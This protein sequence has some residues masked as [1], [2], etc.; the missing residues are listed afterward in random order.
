[1]TALFA[2]GF[3]NAFDLDLLLLLHVDRGARLAGLTERLGVAVT[4][5]ATGLA[6]SS[7]DI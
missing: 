7:R 4:P 2:I 1:L 6:G 3:R 5:A